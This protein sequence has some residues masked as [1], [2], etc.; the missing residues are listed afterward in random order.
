[1][2][3]NSDAT[4]EMT[5]PFTVFQEASMRREEYDRLNEVIANLIPKQ[6]LEIGMA[7]GGSSVVICKAL[8]EIGVG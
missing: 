7:N 3:F 5:N 4:I 6:T 2:A 1:M 8:S